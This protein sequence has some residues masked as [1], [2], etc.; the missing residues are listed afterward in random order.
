MKTVLKIEGLDCANCAAKIEEAV[1]KIPCVESAKLSFMT[2]KLTIEAP[3][4]KMDAIVEEATKI[5]KKIESD[6]T[7]C[8]L[9]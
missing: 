7:V 2:Q 3:E 9:K 5:A 4:D 8:K 1:K 6:V